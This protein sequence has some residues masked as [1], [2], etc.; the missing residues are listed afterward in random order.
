MVAIPISH[1]PATCLR[2]RREGCAVFPIGPTAPHPPEA[3][4]AHR[5]SHHLDTF[6]VVTKNGFGVTRDYLVACSCG[7]NSGLLVSR[8]HAG[9]QV[10]PVS[11]AEEERARRRRLFGALIGSA[12]AAWTPRASERPSSEE[13]F[14]HER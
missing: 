5:D 14:Q 12:R 11:V 4:V 2:E 1:E 3:T 10:C 7:W 9:A 6:S 8:V 13:R